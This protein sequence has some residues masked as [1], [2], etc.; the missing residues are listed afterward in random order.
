MFGTVPGR[1]R[2]DVRG[3]LPLKPA[4]L[5]V[6]LVD[7]RT[8]HPA[9]LATGSG[10]ASST[11]LYASSSARSAGYGASSAGAVSAPTARHHSQNDAGLRHMSGVD[12]SL[13]HRTASSIF[14]A[15]VA[16]VRTNDRLISPHSLSVT[17]S[18]WD[19]M[20]TNVGS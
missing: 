11:R 13:P 18:G 20:A 4:L 3:L 15:I 8:V 6:L 14:A 16:T 9:A 2:A 7:A 10:P 12:R 19:A 5:G 17:I 1:Q